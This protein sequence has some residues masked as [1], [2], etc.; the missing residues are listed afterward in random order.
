MG[1][2]HI[3]AEHLRCF[4]K[5][6]Q[7]KSAA[8]GIKASIKSGT[9]P[10]EVGEYYLKHRFGDA[11]S[12]KALPDFTDPVSRSEWFY[13]VAS[14]ILLSLCPKAKAVAAFVANYGAILSC[15]RQGPLPNLDFLEVICFSKLRRG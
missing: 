10:R 9:L 1:H 15:C 14:D 6:C 4:R 11:G 7:L 13:S 12:E 8:L 3:L 5:C 2:M